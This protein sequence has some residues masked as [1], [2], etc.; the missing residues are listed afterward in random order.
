MLRVFFDILSPGGQGHY[1]S[2]SQHG[3]WR[4]AFKD[5]QKPSTPGPPGPAPAAGGLQRGP[6]D[7]SDP[8]VRGGS[9]RLPGVAPPCVGVRDEKTHA[10]PTGTFR[11]KHI[12][13]ENKGMCFL[14]GC[15]AGLGGLS[16]L[17]V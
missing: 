5:P 4:V 16:I 1:L 3:T 10:T 17:Y 12:S 8:T 14:L 15:S 2:C 7:G 9:V 11:H 13:S 6:S